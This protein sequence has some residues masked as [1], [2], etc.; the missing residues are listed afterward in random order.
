MST[1]QIPVVILLA[2][3]A[4]FENYVKNNVTDGYTTIVVSEWRLEYRDLCKVFTGK[5]IAMIRYGYFA[6][7]TE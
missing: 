1:I 6:R 5:E 3:E 7:A 4:I 2:D